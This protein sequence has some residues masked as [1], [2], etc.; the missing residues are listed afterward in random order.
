MTSATPAAQTPLHFL[1]SPARRTDGHRLQHRAHKRI[2]YELHISLGVCEHS[3][4]RQNTMFPE[5]GC[6]AAK[7][8]AAAAGYSSNLKTR[9]QHI[10]PRRQ[11]LEHHGHTLDSQR[12]QLSADT[13]C[14][15]DRK[16]H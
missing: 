9:I 8:N 3:F 11:H 12:R 6:L 4:V 5:T 14:S 10:A 13:L 15:N 2:L 1:T 16:H 7:Q